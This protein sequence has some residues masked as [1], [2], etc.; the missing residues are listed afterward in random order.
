MAASPLEAAIEALMFWE[1]NKRLLLEAYRVSMVEQWTGVW[2]RSALFRRN[3]MRRASVSYGDDAAPPPS[4]AASSSTPSSKTRLARSSRRAGEAE[5][6]DAG[7]ASPAGSEEDPNGFGAA[8]S[9]LKELREQ[10]R[11]SRPVPSANDRQST[12]ASV[13]DQERSV[14][15]AALPIEAAAVQEKLTYVAEKHQTRPSALRPTNPVVP[16]RAAP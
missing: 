3:A 13:A 15:E 10:H 5:A 16:S 6:E 1:A 11:K 4:T 14:R 12:T 8:D 9:I 2:D 7:G